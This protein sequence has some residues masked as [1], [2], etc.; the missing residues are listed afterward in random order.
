[1]YNGDD[2]T[3]GNRIFIWTSETQAGAGLSAVGH[4]TR[5]EAD[6]HR[7]VVDV[8]IEIDHARQFGL[9]QIAPYRDVEDGSALSGIS[10]KLHRQSHNKIAALNE[11]EASLLEQYFS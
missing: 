4:V 10:K 9:D 11:Q 8:Q 7:I 2:V 6:G 5:C 1:M 3:E